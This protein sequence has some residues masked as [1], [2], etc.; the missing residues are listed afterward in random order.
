MPNSI[1]QN[2]IPW[3]NVML[4]LSCVHANISHNTFMRSILMYDQAS[5]INCASYR[6][7]IL[8]FKE[9]RTCLIQEHLFPLTAITALISHTECA[10]GLPKFSKGCIRSVNPLFVDPRDHSLAS[11]ICSHVLHYSNCSNASS[12]FQQQRTPDYLQDYP[13]HWLTANTAATECSAWA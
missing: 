6:A 11:S 10:A 13:S 5:S 7:F 2:Y 12:S 8:L 1:I 9:S 4:T 3:H